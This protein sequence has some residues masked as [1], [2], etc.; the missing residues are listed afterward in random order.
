MMRI[1]KK[2]E[3]PSKSKEGVEGRS[4]GGK[5]N[6]GFRS[7]LPDFEQGGEDADRTVPGARVSSER[8]HS[9][10]QDLRTAPAKPIIASERKH[11]RTRV[12]PKD[13]SPMRKTPN[14]T[15]PVAPDCIEHI[16]ARV[17]EARAR[18]Q[19]KK[20]KGPVINKH[21]LGRIPL[22]MT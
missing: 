21:R 15:K 7:A 5:E 18:K 16:E 12:R 20:Q 19:R 10:Q 9:N 6:R 8:D 2:T 22:A 14:R 3:G 4:F 11:L 13:E 1:P 17:G